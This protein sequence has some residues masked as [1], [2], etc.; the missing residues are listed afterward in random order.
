[1]KGPSDT[2]YRGSLAFDFARMLNMLPQVARLAD[3][4]QFAKDFHVIIVKQ[5]GMNRLWLLPGSVFLTK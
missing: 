5:C 2:K 4:S 3:P 1:M